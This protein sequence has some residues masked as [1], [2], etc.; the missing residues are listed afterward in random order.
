METRVINDFRMTF[1]TWKTLYS[2]L[3][4]NL[5]KGKFF[6]ELGSFPSPYETLT[7]N[8]SYLSV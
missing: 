1:C 8:N 3:F 7:S 5:G 4:M 6:R 2:E